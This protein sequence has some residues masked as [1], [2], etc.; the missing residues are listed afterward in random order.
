EFWHIGVFYF[1]PK[2]CIWVINIAKALYTLPNECIYQ[3]VKV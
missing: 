3:I 2:S 1:D